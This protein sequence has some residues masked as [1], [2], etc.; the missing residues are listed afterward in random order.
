MKDKA[1]SVAFIVALLCFS[2]P[3]PAQDDPGDGVKVTFVGTGHGRVT[4][5]RANSCILVQGGGRTYVVDACDGAAGRIMKCGTHITDIDAVFITHDHLDHCWGLPFLFQQIV[6]WNE[7]KEPY[8]TLNK[9][10]KYQVFL[11]SKILD[12]ALTSLRKMAHIEDSPSVVW[13]VYAEGVIFNDGNV[14]VTA[15]GNDHAAHQEDGSY[16]SYSFLFE[17]ASGEKLFFS[18]DLGRSFD[19]STDTIDAAGGVDL[20]VCELVHY[21]IRL[22]IEKFQTLKADRI[23]FTH[24][25]DFWEE[26]GSEELFKEFTS[27]FSIPA[28]LVT[29]GDVRIVHSK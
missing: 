26:E 17:F 23:V 28:E 27:Q 22:A 7:K 15:V 20:L 16:A 13:Q 2:A 5:T 29:D 18:G 8:R 25:D 10:K 19:L 6:S 9:D 11:S 3:C 4:A 14:K 21:D 12:K 24:Y 1:L